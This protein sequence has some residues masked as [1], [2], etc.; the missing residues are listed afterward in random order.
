MALTTITGSS[1]LPATTTLTVTATVPVTSNL[2]MTTITVTVSNEIAFPNT[3]VSG[4]WNTPITTNYLNEYL[5]ILITNIYGVPLSLL[6]SSNAGGPLPVG[7]PSSTVLFNA[8]PTQYIFPTGWAGRIGVG[9]NLNVNNSKIESSFTGPPDINVNYIDGYSIPITYSS[10]GIAVFGCNIEL[11][12]QPTIKY[13]NHVKGPVYINPIHALNLSDR[14]APA[15]FAACAGAAY[16]YPNDNDANVS[17]LGS[18]I[19]SCCVGAL[20]EAPSRQSS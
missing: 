19:I 8:S 17:N 14:P 9:P 6:F 15:F 4:A 1:V 5:T 13:N 16:T 12:Q 10:E 7:N 20:C 11:F 3:S 2:P 18:N